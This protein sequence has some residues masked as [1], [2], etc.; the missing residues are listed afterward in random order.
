M[1][2]SFTF[3]TPYGYNVSQMTTR[4]TR[5]LDLV[6][7]SLFYYMLGLSGFEDEYYDDARILTTA[8]W[9]LPTCFSF[10]FS[11]R[12]I[13]THA[14]LLASEMMK[15]WPSTVHFSSRTRL[16]HQRR[17]WCNNISG[18]HWKIASG[19]GAATYWSVAIIKQGRKEED[20]IDRDLWSWNYSIDSA[21]A[22]TETMTM[23]ID[24]E[25]NSETIETLN[26]DYSVFM[27]I[28]DSI[29]LNNFELLLSNFKI[30]KRLRQYKLSCEWNDDSTIGW[31]LMEMDW[32]ESD[33][34][35]W[36]IDN[37]KKYHLVGRGTL[38]IGRINN[39]TRKK[40]SIDRG[41]IDW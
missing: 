32:I 41:G 2:F 5:W 19:R 28:R 30:E 39:Q 21:S 38:F 1:F 3:S 27:C 24:N 17:R 4:R 6:H 7:Y 22:D 20:Y 29:L 25:D 15:I 40:K 8:V 10:S 31:F 14:L 34:L 35:V 26:N 11:T 23:T 16:L 37:K 18:R 13:R 33:T 9:C 36:S 12:F